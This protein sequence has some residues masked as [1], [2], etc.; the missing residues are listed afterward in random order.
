LPEAHFYAGASTSPSDTQTFD[1]F[2]LVTEISDD[3]MGPI[4]EKVAEI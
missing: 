3:M 4:V 2:N 1:I